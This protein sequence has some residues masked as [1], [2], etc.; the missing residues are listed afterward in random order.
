MVEVIGE[1]WCKKVGSSLSQGLWSTEQIR[2]R[3]RRWA[4]REGQ[5]LYALMERAGL[6]LCTYASSHWPASNCW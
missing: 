2:S 3:E 6:A 1:A 5:P 4:E